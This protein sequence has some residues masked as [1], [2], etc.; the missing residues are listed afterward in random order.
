M[1]LGLAGSVAV[2]TGGSS[3][4]GLATARLLLSEGARVAICG[5]DAARLADAKAQLEDFKAGSVLAQSC[6]VRD[7]GAVNAFARNVAD[8]SGGAVGLLVNNAG[9]GRLST[10]THTTDA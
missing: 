9:Q 6:D 2:V 7:A 8:W 4:I 3:G 10:F 5:R 1:D